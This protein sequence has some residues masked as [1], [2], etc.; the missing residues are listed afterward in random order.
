MYIIISETFI[1]ID[2]LQHPEISGET[3]PAN[4]PEVRVTKFTVLTIDKK[5]N[6]NS[7]AT[8]AHGLSPVESRS[9]GSLPVGSRSFCCFSLAFLFHCCN[10]AQKGKHAEQTTERNYILQKIRSVYGRLENENP[11]HSFHYQSRHQFKNGKQL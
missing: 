3:Q 5:Q 11:L 2:S 9:S 6:T 4:R 8:Y 7:R 1:K 10:V